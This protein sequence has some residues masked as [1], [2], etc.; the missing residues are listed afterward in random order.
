MYVSYGCIKIPSR[1]K[2]LEKHRGRQWKPEG[3]M[4][5]RRIERK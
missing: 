3:P 2:Y 1:K 5:H 4:I